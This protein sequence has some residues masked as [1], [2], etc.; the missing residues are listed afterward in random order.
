MMKNKSFT[1]LEVIIAIT[2]LTLAV[3]GSF[4]LIQQ[5]LVAS[6]LVESRLVAYYL[7]QEGI[8]IVKNIRDSNWLIQ[9]KADSTH[10]WKEGILAGT[11]EADYNDTALSFNLDRSLYIDGTNGFYVYLDSPSSEDIETKFKRKIIIN[12]IGDD[13]LEVTIRVQMTERGRIQNIEVINYLHNWYG[14]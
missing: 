10:S 9:H 1:L 4:S 11:W 13:V 12:E 7:A 3:G 6:S 14:L 5:T 8:E 2:I